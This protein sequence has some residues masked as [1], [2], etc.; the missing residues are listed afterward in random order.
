MCF[1]YIRL[2][3]FC[4]KDLTCFRYRVASF[5]HTLSEY[6]TVYYVGSLLVV[7]KRNMYFKAEFCTIVDSL[8]DLEVGMRIVVIL[9]VKL[10][11]YSYASCLTFLHN[12]FEMY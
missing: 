2:S 11:R 8:S 12:K 10:T 6:R 3:V 7:N 1:P 5:F 4:Y 9:A